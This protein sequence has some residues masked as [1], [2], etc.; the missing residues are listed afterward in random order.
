MRQL[1]RLASKEWRL[2]ARNPHGLA[3]LFFMP[4]LFVLIMSLTLKNSLVD[5][6]PLPTT[7]WF[8]EDASPPAAQWVRQWQ[9]RHPG[10]SFDSA[11]ALEEAL[12]ARV[13]QAGVWVKPG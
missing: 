8:L 2:L 7:G 6:P 13:I 4:A 1:Y 5:R 12:A 9:D 10:Q 3:V 11:A